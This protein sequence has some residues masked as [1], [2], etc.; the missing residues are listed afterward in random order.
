MRPCESSFESLSAYV[1]EELNATQEL[2]LRRHLDGCERCRQV[3]HA[4]QGLK[5]LVTTA[6]EIRPVPHALRETTRELESRHKPRGLSWFLWP[7]TTAVILGLLMLAGIRAWFS[8]YPPTGA[9]ALVKALIDD[10]SRYLDNPHAIQV[11]SSDPRR[12][13]AAFESKTGFRVDLPHLSSATL[14]GARFCRLLGHKGVLSFYESRGKRF[15]LFVLDRTALPNGDVNANECRS[16]GAYQVC[17]IADAAQLL[18]M[19]GD[20]KQ[21]QLILPEIED[22]ARQKRH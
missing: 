9:D 8:L 22:Q 20:K 13:A 4:L 7:T 6:A 19:V 1:D 3:V 18:A 12:L 14:L 15:S 17:L 10:H 16:E 5:E 2:Q 21:E 11:A